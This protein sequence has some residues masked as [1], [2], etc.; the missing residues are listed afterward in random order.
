MQ[1]LFD[2]IT[3]RLEAFVNQRDQIALVVRCRDEE[4]PVIL[5]TFEG[6]DEGAESE[7]FW[8]VSEAFTDAQ[9]WVSAVVDDFVV[10]HGSVR[11]AMGKEG[12]A[13][14]PELPKA[15]L[16]ETRR[17]SVRLREL[18][19]F[20]RE[21]RPFPEGML[22]VWCLVPLE[23]GDTRA[24][25][26]LM[27]E[28]LQHEFPNP[29]CHHMRIF[30]RGAP[31]EPDLQAALEAI[32]RVAW[33]DPDLS[34]TAIQRA[35]EEEAADR[36]QPLELRLQNVF[37]SAGVDFAHGRFDQAL[38][39]YGVLLKFY[40]GVRNPGMTAMVLNAIGETHARTGNP[41]AAIRCFELALAPAASMSPMP[42][43]VMLNVTLNLANQHMSFGHWQ[44][45]EAYYDSAQKLAMVQRDADTRLRAIE[46]LGVCQYAQGKVPEAIAKWHAGAGVADELGIEGP[47]RTM[48]LRLA[49]HYHQAQDYA[50]QAEMQRL[51]DA[52][53]TLAASPARS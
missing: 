14:W 19:E 49:G 29:W 2:S 17:P 45:A 1:K 10:K 7:M 53:P 31:A 47:R 37:M 16:D 34:Q 4:C 5:K 24:W 27:W 43:P 38:A 8:L 3:T 33:Y 51:A 50:K 20:S 48:L 44:E 39:K 23:I 41:D 9:T 35:L 12:F 46:N 13:P 42:V 52:A 18:M 28:L 6:M 32:P 26:A 22:T 21:L 25:A 30:V 15:L 36:K 11:M 40:T